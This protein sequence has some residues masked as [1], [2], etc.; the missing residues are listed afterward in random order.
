[1]KC[2]RLFPITEFII[3]KDDRKGQFDNGPKPWGAEKTEEGSSD[4]GWTSWLLAIGLAFI[5]SIVYRMYFT[6]D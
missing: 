6:K 4:G 1:M 3:F 5:A 2:L